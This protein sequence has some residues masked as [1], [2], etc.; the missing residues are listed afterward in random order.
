MTIHQIKFCKSKTQW[1]HSF[2]IECT[3]NVYAVIDV[4]H[5]NNRSHIL[6]PCFDT[7]VDLKETH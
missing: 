7:I 5:K 1:K 4:L 2:N 6:K 3:T